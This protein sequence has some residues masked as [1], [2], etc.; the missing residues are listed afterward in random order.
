MLDFKAQCEIR[1][2]QRVRFFFQSKLQC[3]GCKCCGCGDDG[4][5]RDMYVRKAW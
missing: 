2:S 5:G 4:D 3:L 1:V